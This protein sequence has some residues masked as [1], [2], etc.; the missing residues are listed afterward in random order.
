V[1]V[2]AVSDT[3]IPERASR[4]PREV[5]E[6][7]SG[8]GYD[9]A[10][11]AGDLV[12]ESVIDFLRSVGR[13]VY[14]VRGNTDY[15]RLPRYAKFEVGG[16]VFGVFH[17]DGIYPRGSIPQLSR[18][19]VKL[20]VGVLIS[21]HTHAPFV[22]YDK[23]GVVHVNPGSLTGAWGGW[24]GSGVP[25]LIEVSLGE[26]RVLVE[27]YELEGGRVVRKGSWEFAPRRGGSAAP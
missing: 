4:I 12:D 16:V 14:V 23:V 18:V 15:L 22:A 7:V 9:V 13:E 20:G 5:E 6:F 10:V 25:S 24:G 11:H 8:R 26:G 17:G 1:R 27:L 2:L 3:H 21:G 19:A